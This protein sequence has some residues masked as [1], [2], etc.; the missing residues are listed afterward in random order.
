MSTSRSNLTGVIGGTGFD[1]LDDLK[2]LERMSVTTPYGDPS[3]DML[4]GT[5]NGREYLFLPRHGAG[6][7]I[8]PHR[9]NYRANI[10]AMKSAGAQQVIGFAAVGGIAADFKPGDIVIPH[11]VLDYTWDREHTFYDG[12]DGGVGHIDFTMPYA[13]G[14]RDRILRMARAAEIFVHDGAVYATTQGPRLETAAE[15]DRLER[16]GADIVGMTGM[17]E[18]ALAREAGLD[19]AAIA[20]IVNPA[21]GRSPEPITMDIIHENLSR[22]A[23]RALEIL[24]S[25]GD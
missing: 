11:Q 7:A 24:G 18:A 15:I 1:R 25:P 22:G 17:P 13:S 12:A 4:R 10:H 6:H 14:L 16:D 2:V 9:I 3:D 5:L 8:P 23:G 20:I 19:Y 21:A